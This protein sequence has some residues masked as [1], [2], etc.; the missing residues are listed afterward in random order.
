MRPIDLWSN[1]GW[2]KMLAQSYAKVHANAD[3]LR[4]LGAD[5]NSLYLIAQ[6]NFATDQTRRL[7]TDAEYVSKL[8]SVVFNRG[9]LILSHINNAGNPLSVETFVNFKDETAFDT[10][11]DYF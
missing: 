1:R 10:G 6:N 8:N 4:S 2:V 3:E 5:G 7:N 9:S 11:R